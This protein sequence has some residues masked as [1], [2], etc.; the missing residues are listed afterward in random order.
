MATVAQVLDWQNDI[1]R[2]QN[3][4]TATALASSGLTDTEILNSLLEDA[5]NSTRPALLVWSLIFGATPSEPKL[6]EQAVIAE[7]QFNSYVNLG[8]LNPELGSYEALGRSLS[9]TPEF[10]ARVTGQSVPDVI[11][12]FYVTASNGAFPGSAQID[13]FVDQY[14]YFV[15][16][17]TPV[18]GATNAQQQAL[19][20]VVGQIIGVF[21]T[22]EDSGLDISAENFLLAAVN[23]AAVFGAPL[24]GHGARS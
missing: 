4:A 23:D 6:D 22:Q 16:H 14:S 21:G 7:A 24:P 15:N 20:A 3:M 9:Q 5:K 10:L 17:W 8:V 11:T 13:H 19:G 1:L 12:D 18:I 2:V